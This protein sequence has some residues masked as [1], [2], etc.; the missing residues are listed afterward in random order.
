MR[1]E[2]KSSRFTRRRN[3]SGAATTCRFSTGYPAKVPLTDDHRFDS[4]EYQGLTVHRFLHQHVPMGHQ[5]NIVEMEYNNALFG[6]HLRGF[7]AKNPRDVVH[8]FSPLPSDG[9]SNRCLR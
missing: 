1:P 8:F 5:S 4:Y 2:R 6:N 3:F 7:L 9:D